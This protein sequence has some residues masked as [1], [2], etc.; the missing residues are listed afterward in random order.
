MYAI[1]LISRFMEFSNDS[2]WKVSKRIL[3]YIAGTI[4]Y[5]IWYT[6]SNNNS[7][8]GYTESDFVGS[9]DDWKST[10]SYAFHLRS[11][12]ISWASR[13]HLIVTISLVEVEYV[14]A[15]STTF[16]AVWHRIILNDLKFEDKEP[17]PVYCDNNSTITLSKNHVFHRKSNHI[18]TRYHFIPELVKI[19]QITLK[20]YESKEKPTDIF[21]KPLA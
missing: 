6:S 19:G 20:F 1:I 5:G 8:V 7:L 12:L 16:H 14:V 10:S 15:T 11:C 21:T 17:T 18:D 2:H 9:I 3:R 13:K 4:N